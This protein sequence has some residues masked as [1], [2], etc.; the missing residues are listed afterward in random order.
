MEWKEAYLPIHLEWFLIHSS[1]LCLGANLGS[2]VAPKLGVKE[3]AAGPQGKELLGYSYV[4]SSSPCRAG[5]CSSWQG[6]TWLPLRG[7][8][9]L[10]PGDTSDAW[11]SVPY[12]TSLFT[13]KAVLRS[14]EGEPHK[15]FRQFWNF[16]TAAPRTWAASCLTAFSLVF[17]PLFTCLFLDCE[18]LFKKF[19]LF[20]FG[21]AGS[22]LLHADY[23]LVAA[24]GLLGVLASLVSGHRLQGQELQ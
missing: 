4:E 9:V 7:P 3:C 14:S 20:I 5:C 22:S 10:M 2:G 17:P 19:C 6:Q 13:K 16:V 8:G 12:S 1:C 24:Q 23:S 11:L 18:L 21:C 15:G